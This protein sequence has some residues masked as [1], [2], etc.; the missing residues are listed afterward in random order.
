M[1]DKYESLKNNT[2]QSFQKVRAELEALK[3]RTLLLESENV[4]LKEQL[5][6]QEQIT[7]KSPEKEDSQEILSEKILKNIEKILKTTIEETVSEALKRENTKAAEFFSAETRVE[8]EALERKEAPSKVPEIKPSFEETILPQQDA[9]KEKIIQ[10]YERN[11]RDIIKQNILREIQ[12]DALTKVELRDIIVSQK[13][14]CSKA[15]FYR[16]LEE[17]ELSGEIM[18]RRKNK[19]TIIIPSVELE[20]DFQA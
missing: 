3:I 16:Y 20:L 8:T 5:G 11:K 9:L 7:E 14:Y 15:S 6:R 19:R 12:K 2:F 17:L 13:K 1:G 4:R 10:S 18:F